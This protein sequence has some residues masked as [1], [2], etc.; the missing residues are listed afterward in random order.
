MTQVAFLCYYIIIIFYKDSGGIKLKKIYVVMLVA[1]IVLTGCTSFPDLSDEQSDM[2]SQYIV[3]AVLNN[4][5][6]YQYSFKYDRTVLE[7]TLPPA[8]TFT[9][10]PKANNKVPNSNSN[11]NGSKPVIENVSLNEVYNIEGI[12]IQPVSVKSSKNI[13]TDFS[14]VS[15]D[16]GKKLIIVS[17]KIKN[18]LSRA[19]NV[20]LVNKN[21]RY[22]LTMDGKSYGQAMLTIVEGDMMGFNENIAAG[23]SKEGVLLFQANKSA[24][25][26]KVEIEAV[27]GSKKSV[28]N[29]K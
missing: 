5:K 21:I 17:F 26:K 1:S 11:S 27:S 15:A 18:N 19:Q 20:N 3:G 10:A 4:T 29:I 28:V 22:S 12:N 24:K 23:K 16:A 13:V 7:P 9:P 8:P 14:S 25:V 6:G 2:I